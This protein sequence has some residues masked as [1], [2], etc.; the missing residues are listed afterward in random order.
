[1][2]KKIVSIIVCTLLI[3]TAAFSMATTVN[4]IGNTSRGWSE[5]QKLLAADGGAN[6]RFGCSAEINGNDAIVGAYFDD[7]SAQTNAGSAYVFTYS[8]A[9]WTQQA[10]LTASDAAT[11]DEFGYSV[12]IDGDYAIVGAH[13][14]DDNG[15]E[16]GS[17][18]IFY[19]SG[20]TWSQQ[21]KIKP[22]D[23]AASDKFGRSV[24]ID[25]D[26]VIVGAPGKDSDQGFSY[27]FQRSGTTW[28]QKGKL[29]AGSSK[30][31]GC[32]VSISGD[33][34]VMG[35]YG[36]NSNTGAAHIYQWIS[37]S[38]YG[39]GKLTASD[40]VI[41]DLFGNSVSIDDEYIVIGALG[42]DLTYGGEGAAYIFE[43]PTTGWTDMTE[44]QKITASSASGGDGFGFQVSVEGSSAV[45]SAPDDDDS[46]TG[47]G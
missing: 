34:V 41:Y 15:A 25:G 7:V 47:S 46:G 22:N 39:K 13:K 21:A 26:W 8:G 23:G 33:T 18:Y 1:M 12:S 5:K 9:T 20:T 38:W 3:L 27:C 32:S 40:G 45:I 14:D 35:A 2:R 24:D 4:N 11:D 16:S 44:T 29:G 19:R 43:E 36:T 37:S 17:A 31:L 10:R 6:D 42:H 28:T 30:M